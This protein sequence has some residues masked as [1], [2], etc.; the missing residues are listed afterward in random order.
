[1]QVEPGGGLSERSTSNTTISELWKPAEKPVDPDFEILRWIRM[2]LLTWRPT[3]RCKDFMKSPAYLNKAAVQT[4]C[5]CTSPAEPT[6]P[7]I[8]TATAAATSEVKPVR[9]L[10]VLECMPILEALEL[11]GL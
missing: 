1:L 5:F 2:G 3:K 11:A 7:S 6:T 9:G 8:S 4:N 10:A